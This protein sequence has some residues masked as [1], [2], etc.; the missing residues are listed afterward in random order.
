MKIN[1][2]EIINKINKKNQYYILLGILIF[3]FLLYYFL[4]IR[5]LHHLPAQRYW[6]YGGTSVRTTRFIEANSY[7]LYV[8]VATYTVCW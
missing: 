1:I 6:I 4:F 3:I 2:P 8:F 7:E 5:Y